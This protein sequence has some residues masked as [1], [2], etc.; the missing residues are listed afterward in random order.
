MTRML[1]GK[2]SL[3]AGECRL[4]TACPEGRLAGNSKAVKL[5]IITG[6]RPGT[7]PLIGFS[8]IGWAT[9]D[10]TLIQEAVSAG[11]YRS[12]S[13]FPPQRCRPPERRCRSSW[14]FIFPRNYYKL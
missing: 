7:G 1:K 4:S 3:S 5:W 14:A 2:I 11:N 6:G 13:N 10:Y 8:G 12:A 9:L